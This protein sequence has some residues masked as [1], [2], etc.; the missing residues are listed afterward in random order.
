MKSGALD[1]PSYRS[2]SLEELEEATNKVDTSTF[3]GEGS[4]GQVQRSNKL[5]SGIQF[6]IQKNKIL[7]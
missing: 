4:L 7:P 2:F 6:T 1:L 5:I 3:M